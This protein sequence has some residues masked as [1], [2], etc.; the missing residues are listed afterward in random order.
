MPELLS[1]GTRIINRQHAYGEQQNRF[2]CI[3]GIE[4]NGNAL[5]GDSYV[6]VFDKRL[7]DN[8]EHMDRG[9]VRQRERIDMCQLF[10]FSCSHA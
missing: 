5:V 8:E 9:K 1:I 4:L 10:S 3:A 2:G 7:N 6:V